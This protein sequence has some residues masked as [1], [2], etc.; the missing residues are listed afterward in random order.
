LISSASPSATIASV[1]PVDGLRLAKVLPEAASTHCPLISM[2]L[3]CP[4]RKAGRI[5]SC[6]GVFV[7]TVAIGTSSV[8]L[9]QKS[10]ERPS[11]S[12]NTMRGAMTGGH[13]LPGRAS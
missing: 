10:A 1:S 4:S 12:G 3:S 11:Q 5:Y 8:A 9:P 2:R 7:T 6:E 13:V